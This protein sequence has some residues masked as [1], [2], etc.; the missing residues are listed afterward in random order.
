MQLAAA[1]GQR[2][3][4]FRPVRSSVRR[5]PAQQDQAKRLHGSVHATERRQRRNIAGG[6]ISFE[7]RQ[8]ID[9]PVLFWRIEQSERAVPA[10]RRQVGERRRQ[11]TYHIVGW[12]CWV[13]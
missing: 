4:S 5:Y 12:P 11:I 8:D 6:S 13:V 1:P 7:D 10:C 2:P 3:A 9:T